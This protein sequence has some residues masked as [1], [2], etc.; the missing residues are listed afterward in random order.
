MSAHRMG[1]RKT[2]FVFIRKFKMGAIAGN[3]LT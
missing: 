3:V 2:L 1:F